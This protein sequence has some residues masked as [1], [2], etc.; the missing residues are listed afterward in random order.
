MH[1]SWCLIKLRIG[2]REVVFSPRIQKVQA[3]AFS[4]FL[5]LGTYL[6]QDLVL[7]GFNPRNNTY[8]T[9]VI[10]SFSFF[11]F[12]THSFTPKITKMMKHQQ[13]IKA[14]DD[15]SSIQNSNTVR[16]KGKASSGRKVIW[17]FPRSLLEFIYKIWGVFFFSLF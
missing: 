9:L 6:C 16:H 8:I 5:V 12:L 3:M 1:F 17:Y 15:A 4:M 7:V 13:M 11:Y 10:G 2:K 14:S